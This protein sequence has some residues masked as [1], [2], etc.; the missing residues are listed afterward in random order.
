MRFI[1]DNGKMVKGV[2]RESKFGM[3]VLFM[4]GSG[5]NLR[6]MDMED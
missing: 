2:V 3:M 6:R 5:I 4:K 1:R